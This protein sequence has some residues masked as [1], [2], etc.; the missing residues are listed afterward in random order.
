LEKLDGVRRWTRGFA[1]RSFGPHFVRR[2]SFRESLNIVVDASCED[3]IASGD[4]AVATET[5]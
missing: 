4:R 3:A 2:D 5:N 1:A